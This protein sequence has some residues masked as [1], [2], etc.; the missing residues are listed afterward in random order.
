M[1]LLRFYGV[2]ESEGFVKVILDI[3]QKMEDGREIELDFSPGKLVLQA[4]SN[5]PVNTWCIS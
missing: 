2:S 3:F 5:I 1:A 4:L